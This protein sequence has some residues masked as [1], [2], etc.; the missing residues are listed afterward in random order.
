[1]NPFLIDS[2][3]TLAVRGVAAVLFGVLTL[4]WPGVTLWALVVLF[5]AYALV[6]GVFTLVAVITGDPAARTHRG[7]LVLEGVAGIAAG[8]VTFFW[9]GITALALL[10]VIA[11][12]ALVTGVLE[13][14]AAV[15]LRKVI[16]HEWILGVLGALSVIF[17]AMIVIWPLSG[18]L[19]I[20][21]G[22]GWYALI[23]GVLSLVLAWR[24]HGVERGTATSAQ[25]VQGRPATA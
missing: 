19:A 5:G 4:I 24:L 16:E 7:L 25:K 3:K 14:V 10:Y 18:A 2:W 1:M 6:D 22:I 13:I 8:A 21:W 9:P 23:S 15:Q 20:T 11:A 12:W 17:A